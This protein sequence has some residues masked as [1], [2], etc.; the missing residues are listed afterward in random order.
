MGG[1]KKSKVK[2][3]RTASGS[4]TSRKKMN[5]DTDAVSDENSSS[6]LAGEENSE[7]WAGLDFVE[8]TQISQ[9]DQVGVLSPHCVDNSSQFRLPTLSFESTNQDSL[10]LP[11]TPDV[12]ML[13]PLSIPET[14]YN[15]SIPDCKTVQKPICF[16]NRP[17]HTQELYQ[18]SSEKRI[19]DSAESLDAIDSDSKTTNKRKQARRRGPASLDLHLS[20]STSASS[21]LHP[22]ISQSPVEMVQTNITNVTDNNSALIS[23][24]VDR[25]IVEI[26]ETQESIS[27]KY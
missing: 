16:N 6:E 14:D 17:I 23:F 8:E 22:T 24:E 15:D 25:P 21:I 27:T 10:N 13:P 7:D 20:P 1:K 26:E 2:K 12:E 3:G 9:C 5:V 11:D 19:R 18:V 4:S